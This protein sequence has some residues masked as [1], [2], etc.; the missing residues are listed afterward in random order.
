MGDYEEKKG[1]LQKRA[2]EILD[3]REAL[4]S[5]KGR[6]ESEIG[7]MDLDLLEEE[8]RESRIRLEKKK[9]RYRMLRD[10]Q[11]TLQDIRSN[12]KGNGSA[13]DKFLETMNEY[14][15]EISDNSLA[16]KDLDSRLDMNIQS[17]KHTLLSPELLSEGT[18][19]TVLL[20]FK[21]AVSQM[22]FEKEGG[23]IVLDDVLLD[24]DPGRRERSVKLIQHFAQHN[25]VIF[26]TCDPA[27]A[28]MLGGHRISFTRIGK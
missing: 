17:G 28:D 4:I 5:K 12:T 16:A 21:L 24:M 27:M 20:A 13:G 15:S 19:E 2:K 1:G 10:I 23:F 7:E 9:D 25:Q 18:K 8:E 11:N 14:L 26:T 3:Q 22:F 6:A